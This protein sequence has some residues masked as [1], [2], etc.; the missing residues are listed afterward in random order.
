MISRWST[1]R[2]RRPDGAPPPLIRLPAPSPRFDAVSRGEGTSGSLLASRRAEWVRN[3]AACPF[4]RLAG[5]RCRQADEGR[6]RI[7][8]S[9]A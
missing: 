9:A 4:A 6:S 2:I 3:L 1:R 5:R 8:L 7:P